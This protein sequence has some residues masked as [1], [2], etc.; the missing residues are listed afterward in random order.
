VEA[1]R[2]E[3]GRLHLIEI[4]PRFPAWTYFTQGVGRNLPEALLRLMAG[5]KQPPFAPVQAGKLFIRYAEELIVDLESFES[6]LM[7]GQSPAALR[8]Q[9]C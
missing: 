4:N 1:L 5:D 3:D 6:V 9:Y 8:Y 2:G 7:Q